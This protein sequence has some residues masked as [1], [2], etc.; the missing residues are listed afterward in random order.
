MTIDYDAAALSGWLGLPRL[1]IRYRGTILAGTIWGPVFWATNLVHLGLL[2]LCGRIPI[3]QMVPS[4]NVSTP[5]AWE[6]QPFW[7]GYELP[8]VPSSVAFVGFPLLFFF[9]VFYNNNSY[10]RFYALYG[11][12]VGMGG[13]IMEWTA[14]VKLHS[15][16]ETEQHRWS[17]WNAVR[18]MLAGMFILYYSLFGASV[19]AAEWEKIRQ[20]QLLTADEVRTLQS[21]KGMKPFLPVYWALE[22][23][24]SI[25]AEKAA[26][27]ESLHNDLGQGMRDQHILTQFQEVAFAFRG[28]C[29]QIVNLLKEPVP[30][31]Y[32]H[33]L[34]IMLTIQLLLLAYTTATWKSVNPFFGIPVVAIVSVVLI[35]MRSLAVQL[36]NPF[37]HD[38]VDF[39][40][41]RFMRAAFDNAIAHLKAER[42]VCAGEQPRGIRN[43]LLL[44]PSRTLG[45]SGKALPP[46]APMPPPAAGGAKGAKGAKAKK[47][48]A[49]GGSSRDLMDPA[50]SL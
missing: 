34:S 25:V 18:P 46:A 40:I 30:F 50:Y 38:S 4:T 23:A 29:G 7:Q 37:G 2:F 33:L 6:W 5:D 35:G 22:E 9:I 8:E 17:Q 48:E 14:L 16:S 42:K 13:R 41:E 32:F 10:Q 31:P 36:S 49:A 45:N 47:K 12:C 27:D 15:L 43:P 1:L 21:Y 3:G 19:D 24:R 39:D 11:H 26:V 44:D 28:H 20:F